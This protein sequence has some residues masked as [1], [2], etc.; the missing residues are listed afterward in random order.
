MKE[1]PKYM[2]NNDVYTTNQPL[3]SFDQA[4]Y[5]FFTA[6]VQSTPTIDLDLAQ[7]AL[8]ILSELN[9]VA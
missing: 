4:Y 7:K 1:H 5:L 6:L 2:V 9:N 8:T 3:T